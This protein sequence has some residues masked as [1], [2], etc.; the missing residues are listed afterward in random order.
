MHLVLRVDQD[1]TGGWLHQQPP[2]VDIATPS[3]IQSGN[4]PKR[5]SAAAIGNRRWR[6]PLY[7]NCS[8]RRGAQST[9]DA[10]AVR[11]AVK[12][13]RGEAPDG[14]RHSLPSWTVPRAQSLEVPNP[15]WNRFQPDG[16]DS[17]NFRP[18][19][20]SGEAPSRLGRSAENPGPIERAKRHASH[21][22]SP[23]LLSLRR[24]SS[25]TTLSRPETAWTTLSAQRAAAASRQRAEP[26]LDAISPP[27]F[28]GAD[29]SE[30]R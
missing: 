2:K 29:C 5:A 21:I 14:A 4:P 25:P 8:L 3:S 22:L 7:L 23:N 26:K 6:P 17:K 11:L 13:S 1:I 18:H 12:A 10:F 28:F 20:A 24:P 9:L 19:L 16:V 27:N 15:A 30:S